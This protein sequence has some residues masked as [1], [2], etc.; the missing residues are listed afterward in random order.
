MAISLELQN[1]VQGGIP[2][3]S[4]AKE[5]ID[6][7]NVV[8]VLS[9]TETAFLDGVV[10]GTVAASKAVVVDASKQI[11]ELGFSDNSLLKLG[12]TADIAML[13][14]SA[15]LNA[16]TALTSVL[17]G[18]P[19]VAAIPANSFIASNVTADGDM[20]F[21]TVPA[22]GAN[23]IEWLRNDASA[24]LTVLNEAAGDIDFRIE[25][26]TDA[27]MLV[28]D[29]GTDSISFGS[30]VVAGSALSLSNLTGR[31]TVTS[32]GVQ[33]HVPAATFNDTAG[34]A[35][36]AIMADIFVGI[37]THTA[38]NARTY[39]E[40]ASV[41]IQGAPVASTNVTQTASYA[42]FVDAGLSRFDGV[43]AVTT[44]DQLTVGGVIVGT[45]EIM[46]ELT[47]VLSA[48]KVIYNVFVARDAWQVTHIDYTSDVAQG[49]AL[50][51]TVVKAVGTATPASAT[52]PMHTA[53]AIDLN[54]TA[55]T[56]QPI[57]VTVT[58]ADLQ[59]AAGDRIGLVLSGAIT[60]GSGRLTIRGKRI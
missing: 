5:L 4:G 51:A 24:G 23:S 17:I 13:N 57:T 14:R 33:A 21:A 35:T 7:L 15:A 40:C 30:A 54:G 26:D 25:G 22:A 20:V 31:A 58:T 53:G 8:N 37:Q 47:L 32:V 48:T 60:V 18:T 16:N 42:L 3:M 6:L 43:V 36:I 52:T 46:S 56:V 9:G 1:A 11:S 12:T 34:A 59:L 50:T 38:T 45:G 29:A 44:A 55:H 19:A 28:I 2:S 27:N 41:Y 39:S 10:A 49:G